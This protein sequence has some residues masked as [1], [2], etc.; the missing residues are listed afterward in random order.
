VTGLD[1]SDPVAMEN[2]LEG[3]PGVTGCGIFARRPADLLIVGHENGTF[4]TLE[5]K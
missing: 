1:L 5:R 2:A 3:I 4:D